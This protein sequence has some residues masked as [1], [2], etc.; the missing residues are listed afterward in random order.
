MIKFLRGIVRVVRRL[1]RD[2]VFI[3]PAV[4]STMRVLNC[5]T[6]IALRVEKKICNLLIVD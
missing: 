4:A 5:L 1:L 6:A 3:G 2:L